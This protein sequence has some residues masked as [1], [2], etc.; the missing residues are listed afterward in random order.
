[1]WFVVLGGFG[2]GDLVGFGVLVGSHTAEFVCYCVV[3]CVVVL[4]ICL[5]LLGRCW[6]V[7]LLFSRRA[8]FWFG[9][10]G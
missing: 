6:V 4:M 5:V 10:G 2:F 9:L 7:L 1:M 8:G 3:V